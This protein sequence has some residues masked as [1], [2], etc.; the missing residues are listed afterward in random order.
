MKLTTNKPLI[1]FYDTWEEKYTFCGVRHF[2]SQHFEQN[3]IPIL[4]TENI[5]IARRAVD[6]LNG[7]KF[8]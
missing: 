8:I 6:N 7:Y 4:Y 3:A 5:D 1:V 2:K